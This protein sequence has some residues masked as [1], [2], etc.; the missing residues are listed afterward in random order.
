MRHSTARLHL[1]NIHL[2]R[3]KDMQFYHSIPQTRDHF[4]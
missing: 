4:F 2:E 3:K 1:D